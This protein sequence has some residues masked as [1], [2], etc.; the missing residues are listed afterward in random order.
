M[1]VA[2]ELRLTRCTYQDT[3]RQSIKYSFYFITITGRSKAGK[4]LP[5]NIQTQGGIYNENSTQYR[6]FK[7]LQKLNRKQQRCF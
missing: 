4:G 6:S 3:C 2:G 5:V 1:P 7:L